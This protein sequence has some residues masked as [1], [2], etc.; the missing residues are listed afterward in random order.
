[1]PDLPAVTCTGV[2]KIYRTATGEVHAL[3][4]IDGRFAAGTVN[5]VVGPSGSG[6]SSLLRI[7]AA[8]DR[9]T[10]G[11]VRIGDTEI[12]ALGR[13]SL[14]RV[15]RAMVGYVFQRPAHN[16]IAYLTVVV[17]TTLSSCWSC[18]ASDT[19]VVTGPSSSPEASSSASRSLRP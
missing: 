17:A 12:T 18:S 7:L 1:V 15:R 14:R 2:V 6:K 19:G 10:A 8:L 13:G 9:P 3:K 11:A 16:L 5:A 4:G